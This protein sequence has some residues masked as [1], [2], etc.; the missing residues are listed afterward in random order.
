MPACRR[1]P[2]LDPINGL[3][4]KSKQGHNKYRERQKS[5][6]KCHAVSVTPP[7]AG[8]ASMV[9]SVTNVCLVQRIPCYSLQERTA[10]R[11]VLTANKHGINPLNSTAWS[12]VVYKLEAP[13]TWCIPTVPNLFCSYAMG[14]QSEDSR[15][16]SG[17]NPTRLAKGR[18][19]N[20]DDLGTIGNRC[21]GTDMLISRTNTVP[22]LMEL[23]FFHGN[24]FLIRSIRVDDRD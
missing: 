9:V 17:Y 16:P 3:V 2:Q 10:R 14:L 4:S 6:K 22:R 7:A 5:N 18:A 19:H 12:R 1:P 8:E 20:S 23:V 21:M 15:M 13:T 24:M 11:V